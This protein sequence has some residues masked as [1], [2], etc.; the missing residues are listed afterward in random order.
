MIKFTNDVIDIANIEIEDVR[1]VAIYSLLK[2]KLV[3]DIGY[4]GSDIELIGKK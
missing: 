1:Q 4:L 3:F 2:I